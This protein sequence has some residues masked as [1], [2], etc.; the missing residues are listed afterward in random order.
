MGVM[1]KML[2]SMEWKKLKKEREKK[3]KDRKGFY[4]KRMNEK[5]IE[6]I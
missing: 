4:D 3:I 1:K 2:R 6:V 5:G